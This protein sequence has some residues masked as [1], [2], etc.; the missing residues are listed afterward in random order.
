MR[1]RT[2]PGHGLPPAC[3]KRRSSVRM[4][5]ACG[6]PYERIAR[7]SNSVAALLFSRRTAARQV[8]SLWVIVCPYFPREG[9]KSRAAKGASLTFSRSAHQIDVAQ[10][11][12]KPKE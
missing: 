8:K 1:G 10:G 9:E 2:R 4:V 5:L 3:A 12:Q 7:V 6:G 11:V